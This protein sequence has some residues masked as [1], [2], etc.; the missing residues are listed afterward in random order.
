MQ[1]NQKL[2]YIFNTIWE[3][4][5]EVNTNCK[6]NTLPV[7]AK[8][9]LDEMLSRTGSDYM[10]YQKIVDEIAA[11]GYSISKSDIGRYSLKYAWSA[12]L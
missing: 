4:N 5:K 1:A 10:T 11:M 3:F 7:N 12:V 8:Q 6:V 9:K 2:A